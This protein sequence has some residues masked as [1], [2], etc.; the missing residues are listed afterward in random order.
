VPEVQVRRGGIEPGL[1]AQR[2]AAGEFLHELAFDEHFLRSTQEF[3]Q[4][5]LQFA[6][7]CYFGDSPGGRESAKAITSRVFID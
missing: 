1:D 2:R 3:G 4:L 5:V 7:H 6:I